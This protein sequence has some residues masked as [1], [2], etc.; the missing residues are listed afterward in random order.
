[1][2]LFQRNRRNMDYKKIIAFLSEV[3]KVK[4]TL[5][6]N[7]MRDGRRESVAEHTWRMMVFFMILNDLEDL[8]VNVVKIFKMITLHDIPELTFGD[9]PGFLKDIDPKSHK[10]HKD[11]ET[12]N[13]KRI[14]DLLPDPLNQEYFELFLELEL[15]ESSEAKLVKAIDRIE[16][17]LQH[18]DSGP[19]YWSQEEIGEHMLNYPEQVV[20]KLDN[21]SVSIIWKIIRQELE[22]L[23]NEVVKHK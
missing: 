16:S 3:E 17:Q 1:M 15:G 11:R 4:S 23:T 18:L 5:R 22:R 20:A 19:K 14:F 10:K 12:N 21:H 2:S 7:W 8:K 9:I 13:A 6:H